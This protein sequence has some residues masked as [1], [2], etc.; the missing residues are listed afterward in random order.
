MATLVQVRE[1][2]NAKLAELWPKIQAKQAAYFAKHGK[3]F[4]LL[5]GSDLTLDGS[6]TPF[7]VVC[8]SDEKF[9]VD[10][11]TS[12]SETVPF[13]L[14]IHEWLGNTK[15]YTAIATINYQGML[16]RRERNSDSVDSG[17]YVVNELK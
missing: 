12:W 3:Y 9:V 4:Q 10:I 15:G 1:K 14:E 11:E 5:A 2:A 13:R 6:D 7:S 16:Y 8:P 17:W